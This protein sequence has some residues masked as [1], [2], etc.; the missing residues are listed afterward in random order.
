MGYEKLQMEQRTA[1]FILSQTVI[2]TLEEIHF[3][4]IFKLALES[5]IGSW[6]QSF[7]IKQGIW[8][9]GKT[10]IELREQLQAINTQLQYLHQRCCPSGDTYGC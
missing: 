6:M 1:V 8:K 10:E 9:K 7:S 2:I 3:S 5:C 4:H